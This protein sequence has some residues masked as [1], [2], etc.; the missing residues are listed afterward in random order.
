M[1]SKE[2][3]KFQLSFNESVN[4]LKKYSIQLPDSVIIKSKSEIKKYSNKIGYPLAMKIISGDVIHKSDAGGVETSIRDEKYAAEAYERI[5]T[6][7]KKNIPSADIQ[8]VLVQKMFLGIEIIIGMK[9]DPQ[10]GPVLLVGIG[11]IFVEGMK[12]VSMQIAPVNQSQAVGMIKKI[13]AISLLTG[14]RG[15]KPANLTKIADIIVKISRLSM[16]EIQIKEI[17][18][19]PVIVDGNDINIVDVR[20]VAEK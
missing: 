4:I 6:A 9:R 3:C 17:D 18:L 14:A 5:L 11:G 1:K 15:T 20:I 12:D 16:K 2:K 7:I 19:N 8:G 10:F 13:R